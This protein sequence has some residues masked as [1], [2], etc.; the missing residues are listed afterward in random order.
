MLL[1]LR[2][3]I[4][5]KLES[6]IVARGYQIPFLVI[7]NNIRFSNNTEVASPIPAAATLLDISKRYLEDTIH[8]D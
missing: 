3:W 6:E 7:G 4:E 5:L 1:N 2:S 8:P